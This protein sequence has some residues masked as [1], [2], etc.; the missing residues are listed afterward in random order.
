MKTTDKQKIEKYEQLLHDIQF[1]A[2][3][4]SDDNAMKQLIANI[5]RWSYAHR[6]G[7][8]LTEEEREELIEKAFNVLLEI[9]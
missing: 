1:Y 3:V 4:L 8:H 9:K 5:C 2:E 6:V 7:E